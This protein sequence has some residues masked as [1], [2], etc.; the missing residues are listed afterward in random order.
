MVL[1]R[2][3]KQ[4]FAEQGY[5]VVPRAVPRPRIDAARREVESLLAREPPPAGHQG[6]YSYFLDG[7]PPGPLY[8]LLYG[9]PALRVAESLIAPGTFEAPEQVQVALNI[10]PFEHRTGG[11]HL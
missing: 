8:A 2:R 10:P 1:G 5:L 4:T 3:Q 9:G 6:P 11:P 7:V